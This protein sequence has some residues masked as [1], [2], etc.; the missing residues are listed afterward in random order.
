MDCPTPRGSGRATAGGTARRGRLPLSV[1]ERVKRAVR[2]DAIT[3]DRASSLL[4]IENDDALRRILTDPPRAEQGEEREF[5]EL[6]FL[7]D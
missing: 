6:P 1:L 5:A 3:V 2:D 4:A 7:E